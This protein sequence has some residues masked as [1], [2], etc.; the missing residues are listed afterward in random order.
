MGHQ[1]RDGGM[2]ESM[3]QENGTMDYDICSIDVG[4]RQCFRELRGS[5]DMRSSWRDVRHKDGGQDAGDG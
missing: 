3:M 4:E 1:A 5:N 2:K